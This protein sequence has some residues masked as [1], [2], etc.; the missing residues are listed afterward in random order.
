MVLRGSAEAP[1]GLASSIAF[2]ALIALTVVAMVLV[3]LAVAVPG[4]DWAL[5]QG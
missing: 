1:R 5:T 3:A 4:S 2:L